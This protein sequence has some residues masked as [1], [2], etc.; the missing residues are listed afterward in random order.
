MRGPTLLTCAL[1]LA[2]CG[3]AT[4]DGATTPAPS[5]PA[6]PD[7][8][9]G[10]PTP[11]P[12]EARA[13]A[14]PHQRVVLVD[15][16]RDAVVLDE[17]G[18]LRLVGGAGTIALVGR[19]GHVRAS[20]R[21]A[22]GA[23][24]ASAVF[25]ASDPRGEVPS[26]AVVGNADQDGFRGP[27][28]GE[29]D[30]WNLDEDTIESLVHLGY[31]APLL[32]RVGRAVVAV[33]PSEGSVLGVSASGIERRGEGA[34]QLGWAPGRPAECYVGM[35]NEDAWLVRAAA[36]GSL[37]VTEATGPVPESPAPARVPDD[38][39]M[40]STIGARGLPSIALAADG[41][42]L[43]LGS[44][45]SMVLLGPEGL[46]PERP[47]YG[48]VRWRDGE[49]LQIGEFVRPLSI[50]TVTRRSM[51][52][53]RI[54]YPQESE[55]ASSPELSAFYEWR[56]RAE[57]GEGPPPPYAIEPVCSA[58]PRAR[59][60]RAHLDGT[61][62]TG[63]E[64]F[65]AARPR[66]V[67]R[68]L[69]E[70]R[71]PPG[72]GYVLVAP[73]GRFVRLYDGDTV[74]LV[75]VPRGEAIEMGPWVELASGWVF[76]DVEDPTQLRY[77]GFDGRTAQTT[78]PS[79]EGFSLTIV[80]ATHVLVVGETEMRLVSVPAL[81]VERTLPLGEPT[82]AF[83]CQGEGL[84]DGAGE[85]VE[86]GRCPLRE[87]T[88]AQEYQVQVTRDGAFWL[89]ARLGDEVHVHRA[90][91]GAELVVRITTSGV[92][93][94]GPNGVFEGAGA[95]LDHV[96]VREPGAVGTAAITAGAEARARFERPGL[97]AAFFS[98]GALPT[99]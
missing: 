55:D 17:L 76:G 94:A 80:D 82:S 15:G 61:Q 21:F 77:V 59:C 41:A 12:S 85:R 25:L 69:P 49:T 70:T 50:E 20:H 89:D 32:A 37:I 99:P 72:R 33:N 56:Y 24:G 11:P 16:V 23:D 8:D 86:E 63:F 9:A 96:V 98:G 52:V 88:E 48:D 27:W 3:G 45:S 2:A 5:E 68:T 51:L 1:T 66:T 75:P 30:R 87:L 47:A 29:L 10:A 83:V 62:I 67:L 22:F 58:G 95:V 7:V 74:T 28:A 19:D 91:D 79:D 31:A 84:A 26:H 40:S 92:L 97:V 35:A 65:D 14:L 90:A 4:P 93:V 13:P 18:G 81:Q 39:P 46:S 64:V 54:P 6:S 36:D 34:D 78:L 43:A 38:W 57:E 73:G 44:S 53:D 42:R 71:F 60:V